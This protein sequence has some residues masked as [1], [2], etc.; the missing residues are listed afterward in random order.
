MC[1]V[2]DKIEAVRLSNIE[3]DRV[4]NH[5]WPV[6]S[7]L[8]IRNGSGTCFGVVDRYCTPRQ[9]VFLRVNS[10]PDPVHVHFSRVV[11]LVARPQRKAVA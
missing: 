4:L 8:E 10:E 1:Q 5:E 3:L 7:V 9:L 11:C 6:G 2:K